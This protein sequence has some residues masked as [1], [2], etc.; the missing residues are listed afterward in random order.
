MSK[1]ESNFLRLLLIRIKLRVMYDQF[2]KLPIGTSSER[3]FRAVIRENMIVQF[4]NFIK[5]RNDLIKDP[6]IKV[7]DESLKQCWEPIIKFQEPITQLRHQYIAHIQEGD[8][9]FKRTVNEIID[10]CQFPTR[11]GEILFMVGCILIY[12][13]VIRGNFE[14]EWKNTVK[15]HDVMNPKFLTYGTLRIDDVS[16]KLKQI[17]DEVAT[18]LRQNKLRSFTSINI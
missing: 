11:F 1:R 2:P 5:V 3:L 17:S 18:N 6:K 15:K 13:D 12:C 16:M 9:R 10:E 7:V 8:R 14:T 4:Y